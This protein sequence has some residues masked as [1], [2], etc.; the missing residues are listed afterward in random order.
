[1]QNYFTYIITNRTKKVLYTGVSNNLKRR[2]FEHKEDAL[3]QKI[4]FAGKYNCIYLVYYE[5]FQYIEHAIKREKEIKG[6][7]RRKKEKLINEFNPKWRVLN[8]DVD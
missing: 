4:T 8:N 2:L 1:M 3:G 5:R 6:W 7:I